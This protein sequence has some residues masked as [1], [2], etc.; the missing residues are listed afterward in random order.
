MTHATRLRSRRFTPLFAHPLLIDR[1]S[2]K[3][4]VENVQRAASYNP[5]KLISKLIASLRSSRIT[6]GIASSLLI[7]VMASFVWASWQASTQVAPRPSVWASLEPPGYFLRLSGSDE[8]GAVLG[9]ELVKAWLV[10]IGASNL[11]ETHRVG[12]D[13][14]EIPESLIWANLSGTPIAVEVK[15]HGSAAAFKDMMGGT[16]D[17]GMVSREI[18]VSEATQLKPLGDMRS[19]ASEHVFGLDGIA[20]IVPRSNSIPALSLA[21][22]KKILAGE[23]TNWSSLGKKNLPIHLYVGSGGSDTDDALARVLG[24]VLIANAKPYQDPAKLESDAARDRGAIGFVAMGYVKNTRAVPI[25]DG[26]ATALAPTDSTVKAQSYPLSQQLYF[27]TAAEPRNSAVASFAQ[28]ALSREGQEIVKK[29]SFV[30]LGPGAIADVP[31]QPAI[32]APPRDNVKPGSNGKDVKQNLPPRPPESKAAPVAPILPQPTIAAATPPPPPAIT[33]SPP[34]P[35]P[36]TIFASRSAPPSPAIPAR[37]PAVRTEPA[38]PPPPRPTPPIATTSHAVSA[39]DYPPLAIRLREEGKVLIKY[40][41]SE[42]GRVSECTVMTSSGTST[43]DDA[44]C[45]IAKRS[46]KF[47]PATRDGKAVSQYLGAEVNFQLTPVSA[48]RPAPP[49]Q[50]PAGNTEP[51]SPPPPPTGPIATTSHAVAAADYPPAA[52]RLQEQGNVLIKYLVTE[53]GR[54]SECNVMVSSGKSILD[55]A[56]CALAEKNWKFKP[57]TEEGKPVAQYLTAEVV[58]Q[59][60]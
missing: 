54:V 31:K 56:A 16:A 36:P 23:I 49:A 4:S 59:L 1:R 24:N 40:L 37:P 47:K 2:W 13:G 14:K 38:P 39:G 6:L 46:W 34:P 58:F 48:S 29:A 8:I 35:L 9:P 20:V 57:A 30:E 41:V 32:V 45:S 22:I 50:S 19:Q 26:A 15:A 12:T 60:K 44:A 27:Y 28:F 3:S 42:D 21:T 18:N 52:V 10:S 51:G 55:D 25:G 11:R 5:G 53:S 33:A 17:I 43:L 7:I